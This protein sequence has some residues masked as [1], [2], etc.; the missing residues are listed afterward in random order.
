MKK[1]MLLGMMSVLMISFDVGKASNVSNNEKT[2][3]N[4]DF[5]TVINA[6]S[7]FDGIVLIV[8]DSPEFAFKKANDLNVVPVGIAPAPVEL[9]LDRPSSY[10]DYK[11]NGQLKA[12]YHSWYLFNPL[13]LC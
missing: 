3:V 8:C 11:P 1:I 12:K 5:D 4:A 9:N 13:K 6:I 10:I 2:L 7:S